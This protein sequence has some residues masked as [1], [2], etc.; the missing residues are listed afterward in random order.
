MK[1]DRI[2]P[3]TA[4]DLKRQYGRKV[5]KGAETADAA[6]QEAKQAADMAESA[7]QKASNSAQ[8]V[9]EMETKL[10]YFTE[11]EDGT[12][13][14]KMTNGENVTGYIRIGNLNRL[15]VESAD[16][17]QTAGNG[18]QNGLTYDGMHFVAGESGAG[19]MPMQFFYADGEYWFTLDSRFMV[20]GMNIAE[21]LADYEA[22]IADLE[23]RIK[24]LEGS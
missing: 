24:T 3:R 10:A 4:A 12:L 19:V 7:A 20:D 9:A 23:A 16:Y 22:R 17:D 15:A 6:K 1:Q 2:H 11:N 5:T 18:F 14:V 13:T 8:A 21:K